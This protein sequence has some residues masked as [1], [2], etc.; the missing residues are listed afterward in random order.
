MARVIKSFKP[1][2][3]DNSRVLILG[4]MPGPESLRKK[5]YYANASNQFWRILFRVLGGDEYL[6]SDYGAKKDFLQINRIALW[7][8]LKSCERE[9]ASDS[10]II[11]PKPNNFKPLLHD[12]PNLRRV[13]FNGG[14]AR[15]LFK[16]VNGVDPKLVDDQPLPS[17][18]PQNR[19]ALELK[20]KEWKRIRLIL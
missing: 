12:Y 11:N 9:D 5:Q 15:D 13:F 19:Q 17:S 6:Y 14:V 4:T 18:S 10:N 7:D 8:V 2:I 20:V 3:D 16:K 1:I